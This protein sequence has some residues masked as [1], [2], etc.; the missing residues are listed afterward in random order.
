MRLEGSSEL[1]LAHVSFQRIISL[2]FFQFESEP[3]LWQS[4]PSHGK[5]VLEIV[6]LKN[7]PSNRGE[8]NGGENSKF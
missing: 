4:L 3:C 7:R 5:Q 6:P 2:N 1:N 8:R